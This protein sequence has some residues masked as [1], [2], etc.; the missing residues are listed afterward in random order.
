MKIIKSENKVWQE[1]QGYNKKI[2][3]EGKDI[4]FPGGLLQEL[5]IKPGEGAADHY[6]KKQTEIFYFLNENGYWLVNGEKFRMKAGDVLVIEPSDKH[7][8]FNDTKEDY[9][10]LAFKYNYDPDDLYWV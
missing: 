3:L 9:L 5:K 10:Y 6:H 8:A 7:I 2:F 1:K 4:G